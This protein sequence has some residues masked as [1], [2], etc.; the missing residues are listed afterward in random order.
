[1]KVEGI[2]LI[3]SFWFLEFL[4]VDNEMECGGGVLELFLD[5]DFLGLM[6][7]L[8]KVFGNEF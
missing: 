7:D 2:L 8:K 5:I 6:G 4:L 3:I 1:M